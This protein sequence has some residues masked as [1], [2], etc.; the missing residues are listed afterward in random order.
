[1]KQTRKRLY[2]KKGHG[3]G[4]ISNTKSKRNTNTKPRNTLRKKH[5]TRKT[6]HKKIHHTK[7]QNTMKHRP[8]RSKKNIRRGRKMYRHKSQ[9]G[10]VTYTPAPGLHEWEGT[11]NETVP[12]KP[13][14][15]PYQVGSNQ[16]GLGGGYYYSLSNDIHG[17]RNFYEPNNTMNYPGQSG[18]GIIP[19][20]IVDLGR[21]IVYGGKSVYSGLVGEN[22]SVS[23]NPNSTI[24]NLKM[25]GKNVMPTNF[26][27][28]FKHSADTVSKM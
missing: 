11:F 3:N 16:N 22:M 8:N 18:G 7:K 12:Y 17:T 28:I 9:R 1:M 24:Q 14:G 21:N 5:S 2:K 19:Q 25:S 6:T 27:Q 20:D 13:P 4:K 10:G 23:S 15:G 26:N